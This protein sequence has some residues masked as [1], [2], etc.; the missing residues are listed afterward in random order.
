M[1]SEFQ[2]NSNGTNN[3]TNWDLY[4]ATN[5]IK[6]SSDDINRNQSSTMQVETV[7]VKE[8]VQQDKLKSIV[9]IKTSIT[10]MFKSLSVDPRFANGS[11]IYEDY[12][13]I[14]QQNEQTLP[15]LISESNT[16]F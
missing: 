5:E 16:N 10:K 11:P 14:M 6:G 13:D 1:H 7:R 12:Q 4:N 15:N 8:L 9:D 3:K 2:D